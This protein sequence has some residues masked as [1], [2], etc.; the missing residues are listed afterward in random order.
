MLPRFSTGKALFP[1]GILPE[2]HVTL[3]PQVVTLIEIVGWVGGALI[4]LAYALVTSGRLAARSLTYQFL[5]IFGAIGFI[6][7]S[8]WNGAKPSVALNVVW[9]GIGIYTVLR[10]RG[11]GTGPDGP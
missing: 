8:G 3:A 9:L 11:K 10:L 2:K 7:N 1:R 4:L 5:N 6:I